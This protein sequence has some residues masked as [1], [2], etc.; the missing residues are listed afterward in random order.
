MSDETSETSKP[1]AMPQ[2]TVQ[3]PYA[4]PYAP[5]IIPPQ[6]DPF[7]VSEDD[8]TLGML[9]HLLGLLTGF[10]GIL[11]LWLVK[12]DQS[13]F[14]DYHG[15]EAINFQL[16]LLIAVMVLVAFIIM[17]LGIGMIIAMPIIGG[18]GIGATV[19]EIIACVAASR[20]EWHRYPLT[21]RFIK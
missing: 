15:K 16:T 8:R 18:I 12:K 1:P 19:L 13:R 5:A 21:I 6:I 4:P 20:G 10:I 11:I 2:P 17:T 14:V 9:I 7:A 3:N